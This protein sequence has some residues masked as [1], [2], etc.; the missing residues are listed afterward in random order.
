MPHAQAYCKPT[1]IILQYSIDYSLYFLFL[2]F[3]FLLHLEVFRIGI[4]A[5]KLS[6]PTLYHTPL[7]SQIKM[8]RRRLLSF[9]S[10]SVANFVVT[11]S[12]QQAA[13]TQVQANVQTN[14]RFAE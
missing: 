3:Y 13:A 8:F 12:E 2:L 14:A 9:P 5:P 11:K 7:D 1:L 10:R 4:I 6:L